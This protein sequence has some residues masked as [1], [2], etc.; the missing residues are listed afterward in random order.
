MKKI[1]VLLPYFLSAG[2]AIAQSVGINNT[3]PHSSAILDVRSNTK[4]TLLPRTSTISRLAILNPAKGLILYDSTV[5]SF[6]FY[7]GTAWA[8]ISASSSGWSLT[9]NA[10]TNPANNFIGT[11]NNQP[12]RFRVNNV[13]AGE[14]HPSS[15]NVFIGVN[16]GNSATTGTA[17][18]AV[19]ENSLFAITDGNFNTA[20]GYYSLALNKSG[21]S[22]TAVGSYALTN[23]TIGNHNTA[24]GRNALFANTIGEFNTAIGEGALLA[25]TSGTSN[26]AH[27]YQ[28]LFSDIEGSGNTAMGSGALF[29]NTS[30]FYNTA[31][32]FGALR[33]NIGSYNTATGTF[34][35]I[36]NISGTFNT[37][38]GYDALGN[39]ISGIDNTANGT[40]ALKFNQSGS[41][42]TAMGFQALFENKGN[43][44]TATGSF[45]LKQSNTGNYNTAV[46]YGA[47]INNVGG[48]FNIAIGWNSGTGGVNAASLFNTIGIGNSG[49][50]QNGASNQAIIGD[51]NMVFIGGKVNWGVV[52][53]A[54]IKNTIVE[55]VK[56]LDFILRLRPVTYYISN[57]AMN[58]TTGAKET[59]D[60][61]GK[62]DAEKIKYS[63]F[64]AQ[65]V[66]QAAKAAHYEFSG[67]D[68]PK[69]AS[70][71]YTLK[72]AEF[73]VPLTKAV[74]EQQLIIEELTKQVAQSKIPAIVG[75]Q[76]AIIINQ[77][78][79]IDEL[80]ST[81]VQLKSEMMALK[82]K[83]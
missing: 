3:T 5:S 15:A 35:L 38:T 8:P 28:A 10:G 57:Q 70:Q 44:N 30:G 4:G 72:Y 42:N 74:Q 66:E 29:A 76:Q 56:G 20:H 21:F 24:M 78:Q 11:T 16:A 31:N 45:A 62:Y 18:I 34:S 12:L 36:E 82:N 13:W 40:S 69:T 48:N 61:S 2:C 59:P 43:S 6:Y 77:Q 47:L 32:G 79:Q 83:Y 26:T 71:M 17:N 25:N 60:F 39:N 49:A 22:N 50:F 63:G 23:N 73:V 1:L 65:E 81:M 14:I 75:K 64:L 68:V 19:G 52:S 37:A 41:D 51:G 54:R 80:K 53:D 67:Y 58:A 46:G 7:N 55:D 33:K 9:G 27:G